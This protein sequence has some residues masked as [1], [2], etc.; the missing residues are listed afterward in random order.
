M[1]RPYVLSFRS[2]Q[3]RTATLI[4]V[5][6]PERPSFRSIEFVSEAGSFVTI[7][8]APFH[9]AHTHCWW[10]RGGIVS[11][12]RVVSLFTALPDGVRVGAFAV[13]GCACP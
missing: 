8:Y 10:G 12:P 13:Q 3:R 9:I 1:H 11:H 5:V 4:L 2:D 7:L 6:N